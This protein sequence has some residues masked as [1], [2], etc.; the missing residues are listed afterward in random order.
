MTWE[1]IFTSNNP[2]GGRLINVQAG[3]AGSESTPYTSDNPAG[4]RCIN[5]NIVS[6]GTS[7]GG[8]QIAGG[9]AMDTTLRYVTDNSS[10]ANS[11]ILQLS[12]TQAAFIGANTTT[13]ILAITGNSLTTGAALAVSSSSLTSGSLVTLASTSTAAAANTQTVLN[14]ATSGTN[15]T[16]AMTTY[17]LQV[18]NTHAGTTSTNVAGYFTASGGTTANYGIQ[19]A[20]GQV[21]IN[22]AGLVSAS[23]IKGDGAWYT[24]GSATTTKPYINIEPSGT[25][26]TGWSTSGTGL[27]INATTGFAGNLID[28][29]VNGSSK[30]SVASNGNVIGATISGSLIIVAPN[31]YFGWSGRTIMESD[32]EGKV[33]ISD[34]ATGLVGFLR[35]GGTGA[36]SPCIAKNGTTLEVLLANSAVGGTYT[37]VKGKLTTETN[38]TGTGDVVC[39]GYLTLYDATGTAYKVMTTA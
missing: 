26:S 35:L 28:A 34:F 4:G 24:G 32:T 36:G 11:S 38:F 18:A 12:T 20:A 31:N 37:N 17:G 39:N 10:P 5:V 19:V 30:F 23:A 16:S 25:T 33:N 13:S 7:T 15:G 21:V 6:G 3:V 1:E 29:Q 27:G 14:I 22:T 9:V 8:L 2:A